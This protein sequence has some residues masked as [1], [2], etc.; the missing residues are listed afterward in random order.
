LMPARLP[1]HRFFS[2]WKDMTSLL[3]VAGKSVGVAV[4]SSI[5]NYSINTGVFES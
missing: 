5:L 1:D 3:L 4:T 2:Y